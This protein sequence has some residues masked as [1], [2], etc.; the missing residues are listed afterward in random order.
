MIGYVSLSIGIITS[1]AAYK[2]I[3]KIPNL[4]AWSRPL[5]IGLAGFMAMGASAAMLTAL[6][7]DSQAPAEPERPAVTWNYKRQ[8]ETHLNDILRDPSSLDID[9]WSDL[10]QDGPDEYWVRVRY[11]AKNGFGALTLADEVY[12]MDRNGRIYNTEGTDNFQSRKAMQEL[13]R[14]VEAEQA[15]KIKPAPAN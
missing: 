1:I 7:N 11:R 9:G 3:G 13:A 4:S 6:L 10:H 5:A 14:R 8:V 12:T 2:A 15:T